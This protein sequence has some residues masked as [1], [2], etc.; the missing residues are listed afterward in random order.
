MTSTCF[1]QEHIDLIT[2]ILEQRRSKEHFCE[3]YIQDRIE[4]DCI[5]VYYYYYYCSASKKEWGDGDYK[6][7]FPILR[8]EHKIEINKN[9]HGTIKDYSSFIAITNEFDSLYRDKFSE[10]EMSIIKNTFLYGAK[11]FGEMKMR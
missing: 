10:S 1:T 8:F 6:P 2:K 4:K 11:A 5:G 7:Y 3:F 9:F